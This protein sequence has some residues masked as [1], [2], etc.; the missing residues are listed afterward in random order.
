MVYKGLI[1]KEHRDLY[2]FQYN[3]L[4]KSKKKQSTELKNFKAKFKVLITTEN[5]SPWLVQDL[6][7]L[8]K[9]EMNSSYPESNATYALS[10]FQ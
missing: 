6:F 7:F 4:A 1:L 5:Y 8:Y 10:N 9:Y 3:F 2:I